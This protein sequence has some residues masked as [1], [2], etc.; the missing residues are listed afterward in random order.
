MREEMFEQEL[1]V[2]RKWILEQSF[3][4]LCHIEADIS[5]HFSFHFTRLYISQY[6][7]YK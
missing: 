2:W 5:K 7:L 4:L 6:C 3:C 1:P